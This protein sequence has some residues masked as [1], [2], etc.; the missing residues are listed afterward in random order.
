MIHNNLDT[1]IGLIIMD[2]LFQS[3]GNAHLWC[4]ANRHFVQLSKRLAGSRESGWVIFRILFTVNYCCRTHTT[5]PPE[6]MDRFFCFYFV[7]QQHI[8][9]QLHQK[10]QKQNWFLV[11]KLIFTL[12]SQS[13]FSVFF[14]FCCFYQVLIVI[15]RLSELFG[16]CHACFIISFVL[17]T[18][19]LKFWQWKV[20]HNKLN[21][22]N[23]FKSN[24]NRL[25][26]VAQKFLIYST[27]GNP[28]FY[29]IWLC[30]DYWLSTFLIFLNFSNGSTW[31]SSP[32]YFISTTSILLSTIRSPTSYWKLTALNA[33]QQNS[34]WN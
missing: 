17:V 6:L 12:S 8:V 4:H 26:L 32:G 7:S 29:L 13:R 9:L 19:F 31:L 34:C 22:K 18:G 10:S 21:I 24:W 3:K 25:V 2:F 30:I 28:D 15:L 33:W 14:L 23:H 5:L 27:M 11:T 20:S 1:V 16:S